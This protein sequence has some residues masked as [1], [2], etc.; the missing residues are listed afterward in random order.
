MQAAVLRLLVAVAHG[1]FLCGNTALGLRLKQPAT[2][3]STPAGSSRRDECP[4]QY[5]TGSHDV[6]IHG[7]LGQMLK[8]NIFQWSVAKE[9]GWR[10][11][12]NHRDWRSWNHLGYAMLYGAGPIFGCY[13]HTDAIAPFASLQEAASL[14]RVED[15]VERVED[16]LLK[17]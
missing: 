16:L 1:I 7:G 17:A 2:P 14:P 15:S 9:L 4:V 8:L 6:W 10:Y 13:S 11:V 3:D 5:F 12:C